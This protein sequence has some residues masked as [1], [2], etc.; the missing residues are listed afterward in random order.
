MSKAPGYLILAGATL[1]VLSR[2]HPSP[3][4]TPVP[5]TTTVAEQTEDVGPGAATPTEPSTSTSLGGVST[6]LNLNGT[7]AQ[8]QTWPITSLLPKVTPHWRAD[9]T[10]DGG[11]LAL[12]VRIA[13]VLNR[14][15]QL[16][17]ARADYQTYRAEATAWL[18]V[19]GAATYL[20][21]WTPE[22]P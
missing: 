4:P 11:T 12:S 2:C 16:P 6:T 3:P 13:V 17:Q 21:T 5:V 22:M 9:Y 14:A 8:E 18:Q 1:V 15:D 20:V 19:H 10:V 7:D